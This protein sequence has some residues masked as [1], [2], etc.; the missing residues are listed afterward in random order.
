MSVRTFW[1]L[2]T[3]SFW[4]TAC[5]PIQGPTPACDTILGTSIH[6]LRGQVVGREQL[7]R[8]V[9]QEYGIDQKQ[10]EMLSLKDNPFWRGGDVWHVKWV[11]AGVSYDISVDENSV[12]SRIDILYEA[13]SVTVNEVIDCLKQTPEH[14]SAEY[15]HMFTDYSPPFHLYSFRL[16]FTSLGIVAGVM[17]E[18]RVSSDPPELNDDIQVSSLI[19]VEP[20]SP[21]QTYNRALG[22]SVD[23]NLT[24]EPQPWPGN[25][26]EIQFVDIRAE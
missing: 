2:I 12:V 11:K 8:L 10:I 5:R 19:Y 15:R 9:E 4:F 25:W 22:F 3:V 20:G 26:N 13:K 21:R 1:L 14:Y 17:S 23:T 24:P 18:D 6:D 7:L 16:L